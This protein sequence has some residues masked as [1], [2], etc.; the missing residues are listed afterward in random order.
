MIATGGKTNFALKSNG[1]LWE[2][3]TKGSGSETL[4]VP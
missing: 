3:E 2:W 1:T 4:P